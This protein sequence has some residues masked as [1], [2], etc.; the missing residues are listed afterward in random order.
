[1]LE[2]VDLTKKISKEEYKE[3]MPQLE[4]KLGRLQRECKALGIPVLIVF[5]GFGAAGKGLQIGHLIQ[6][7]DPRGF[8][9]HPVKN[10]TEEERMHPFMWRFWTKTPARGRIAI[11]DGSW[12]RKVLIDR[13][14]KRTKAKDLPAAFHSINSFEQ[15]LA[16]DGNLIIKLF[17][18]IDK[19]EQKKRFDKLA[20]N[21][22]TAWRVSQGDR[23]RNAHYD[24]Y[25]ALMEDML[26]NTDTDY[27]PWTIVES[28]D[29]RFATLKIYTTVIKAMADQ[30]EKVQQQNIAKAVEKADKAEAEGVV[31]K[32]E[33]NGDEIEEIAREAD[34]QMKDLQ[35]SILSKADLSLSY[36][37]EEYKEKLDKLQKKMEKLHGELYRR[38]IPVVLGFEGW[39]AGGKGGA[40]KRL[41]AKMD[42]RGYVV[43]PT[44]S[45]N[46]IEKA[47][48]YLWRFWRAMPKDGHVAIFDRT[49]YGRVMV[50]RIEGFCTTEEW[51]R[52]Y[53]EINDME[54]DLYNAG[55]IVIKFWMHIDKDEQE[56]RFKERQENPEKQW[57]ITDE[58]WRNREKWDQ[59][60]DA[61][62][63]MLMRTSTDYA[64]WVVVEGNSKYYA[65]VKVLQTVV[66]AI[67][68]RLKEE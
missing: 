42:A 22:E 39:D 56:R 24:E 58:D 16:D 4:S 50:E 1:M 45:P 35:V 21:K 13:F 47:H 46:D 28:M 29:R 38:R 5:E 14:E 40:I 23:E 9:V 10:E 52:A 67:E 65:R 44:A 26:F 64:P 31:R 54:K 36:T 63:E 30:I 59:Y 66:D 53:K 12:Y 32:K 60:E 62:N 3:K 68:K 41:T 43:N 34:A 33:T 8:E 55:A 17:L 25:A 51:K 49:W 37:R 48:H 20:K 57:K 15:Q 7:M 61:V 6:S 19:K 2:K 27:A 11:F 18:D